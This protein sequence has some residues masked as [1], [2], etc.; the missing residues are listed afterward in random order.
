MKSK[1]RK[2]NVNENSKQKLLVHNIKQLEVAA[3]YEC[4]LLAP[5]EGLWPLAT[6]GGPSGPLLG[7]FVHLN[8]LN[9]SFIYTNTINV[10]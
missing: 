10:A 1:F 8:F 2:I 9:K 6:C 7:A 3:P 5:A 4:L